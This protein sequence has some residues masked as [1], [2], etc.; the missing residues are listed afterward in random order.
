MCCIYAAICSN[1]NIFWNKNH[2]VHSHIQ[3]VKLHYK[4][5]YTTKPLFTN[6]MICSIFSL[7][8]AYMQQICCK[9]K[10]EKR[11][12]VLVKFFMQEYSCKPIFMLLPQFAALNS[13]FPILLSTHYGIFRT[14]FFGNNFLLDKFLALGLVLL[15]SAQCSTSETSII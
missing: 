4:K 14:T 11:H 13:L 12:T 2:F 15:N 1:L 7:Y 10:F 9:T 3:K 6:Y 5:S 8:V